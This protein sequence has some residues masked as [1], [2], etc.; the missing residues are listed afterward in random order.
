MEDKIGRSLGRLEFVHH[1][2]GD[3]DDDRPENLALMSPSEHSR[4]HRAQGD[5]RDKPRQRVPVTCANCGE[6]FEV[7]P[8]RQLMAKYCSKPCMYEYRTGR[9]LVRV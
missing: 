5:M 6:E 4:L 7:V 8:S 9:S 2:N 1:I 3:P